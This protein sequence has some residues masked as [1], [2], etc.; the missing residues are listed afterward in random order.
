[1]V[2][3]L[4]L[5]DNDF[6]RNFCYLCVQGNRKQGWEFLRKLETITKNQCNP[7]HQQAKAEKSHESYQ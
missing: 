6:E 7:L 5:S 2:S 4:K 1:M 3:V